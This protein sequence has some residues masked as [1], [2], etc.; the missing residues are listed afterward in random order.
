M[1]E[2]DRDEVG[3]NEKYATLPKECKGRGK[4]IAALRE[5]VANMK[6]WKRDK[7]VEKSMQT[8]V[9]GVLVAGTQTERRTYAS[10]L[11]HT[12][13]VSIGGENTDKMY[14]DTPPPLTGKTMSPAAT[15]SANITNATPTSAYLARALGFTESR[16]VDPGRK[17]YRRQKAH[18]GDR[19]EESLG[20][21]GSY[22]VMEGEERLSARL[23][24]LLKG[25]FRLLR[26]YM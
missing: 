1:E 8:E 15:L 14:I 12:E 19:E 13:V 21:D 3:G 4:E 23:L 5:A 2:K 25:Q 20:Y 22:K 10:I 26:T 16:V 9:T 24:F 6:K 7:E 17:K 18:S 11:V